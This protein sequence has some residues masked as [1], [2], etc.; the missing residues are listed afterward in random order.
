MKC[1]INFWIESKS[2]TS[3]L[4]KHLSIICVLLICPVFTCRPHSFKTN[5]P[6]FVF[7][8]VTEDKREETFDRTI[9]QDALR[10]TEDIKT[11]ELINV[12]SRSS[13]KPS[14]CW[15]NTAG[16]SRECVWGGFPG[17]RVPDSGFFSK[18]VLLIFPCSGG[19]SVNELGHD[20]KPGYSRWR[21]EQQT[22]KDVLGSN[23]IKH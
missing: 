16:K 5:R 10:T 2:Y 1:T 3:V 4:S 14:S 22:V 17:S 20:G 11:L 13:H 21:S 9:T 8:K 7:V 19:G 18:P 15:S 23:R 6:A 12:D